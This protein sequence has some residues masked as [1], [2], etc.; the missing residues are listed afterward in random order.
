[1]SRTAKTVQRSFTKQ[2][3]KKQGGCSL[4]RERETKER[5]CMFSSVETISFVFGHGATSFS[6]VLV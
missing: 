6:D 1:M 4:I 2:A 3:E 5:Q